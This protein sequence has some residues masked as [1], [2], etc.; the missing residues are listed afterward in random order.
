MYHFLHIENIA[1]FCY[2]QLLAEKGCD[3][4]GKLQ[5][6]ISEVKAQHVRVLYHVCL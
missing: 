3:T 2:D 5:D 6:V 1:T 4:D